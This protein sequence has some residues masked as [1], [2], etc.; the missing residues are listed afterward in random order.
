MYHAAARH[1]VVH[2]FCFCLVTISLFLSKSLQVDTTKS[3]VET[4][5][6]TDFFGVL[7]GS[8]LSTGIT[9]NGALN[10]PTEKVTWKLKIHTIL[11]GIPNPGASSPLNKL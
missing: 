9:T 6:S 4:P 1:E 3:G 11:K 2:V 8:I 5:H 10:Y 7:S